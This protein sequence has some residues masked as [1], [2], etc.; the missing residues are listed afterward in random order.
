MVLDIRSFDVYGFVKGFL[1][2]GAAHIRTLSPFFLDG[3]PGFF[4]CSLSYDA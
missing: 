3:I 1:G 4:G 2:M